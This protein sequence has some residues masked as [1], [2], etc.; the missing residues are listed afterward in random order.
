MSMHSVH[1]GF[2][3]EEEEEHGNNKS[4]HSAKSTPSLH[5]LVPLINVSKSNGNW[6][7][8]LDSLDTVSTVS[9][10]NNNSNN[11]VNKSINE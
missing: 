6:Q 4:L 5:N 9:S 10:G 7:T 11:K 1:N 2:Y 3:Y 8:S